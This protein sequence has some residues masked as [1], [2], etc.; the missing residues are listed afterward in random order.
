MGARAFVMP[1]LRRLLE[2]GPCVRCGARRRRVRDGFVEGARHRTEGAPCDRVRP[3][4]RT[5][6]YQFLVDT[7]DTE[8]IKVFSV[9]S[10]FQDDDLAVR[11]RHDD[12]RGR[13][14]LEHFVHQ[15][16]A[17]TTGF[18]TCWGSMSV[19]RLCRRMRPVSFIQR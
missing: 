3:L 8:R 13:S 16:S 15:W 5:M 11:P 4:T 10:E 6:P 1:R 17:R 2:D 19:R 7:Y 14:V 12:R 18:A 9:W